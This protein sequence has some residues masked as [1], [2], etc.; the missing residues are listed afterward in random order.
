MKHHILVFNLKE[1]TTKE[2]LEQL[3][4]LV[5]GSRNSGIVCPALTYLSQVP[6]NVES[7]AQII[8]YSNGTGKIRGQYLK[9]IGCKYVLCG[10]AD[11]YPL[12]YRLQVEEAIKFA[13]IPIIFV[14]DFSS[15]FKLDAKHIWVY[16]PHNNI[17]ADSSADIDLIR[18][19][20]AQVKAEYGTNQ[21]VLYGGSVNYSN[22][23][24]IL[25]Y[26]D[27]LVLG[28]ASRDLSQVQKILELSLS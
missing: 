17:G 13:L 2:Y 22:A 24:I 10:H 15:T 3:C 23:A 21:T 6:S 14:Q 1:F 16:E 19:F 18:D 9:D 27:G 26:I 4:S 7:C 12:D 25:N 28:R 20:A 11:H 8:H 5:S